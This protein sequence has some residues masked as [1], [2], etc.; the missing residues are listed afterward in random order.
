MSSLHN[1]LT[2]DV[3]VRDPKG[4]IV[5]QQKKQ[6]GKSLLLAWHRV[7]H[8]V[9]GGINPNNITDTGGASRGL[10]GGPG[11]GHEQ[12]AFNVAAAAA[13]ATNGI[14][15]GRGNTAVSL[16]DNALGTP[17]A[18][19][20]GANQLNYAI[21]VVTHTEGVASD[22]IHVQRTAT[23]NSAAPITVKEIGLIA[24]SLS[25]GW[26]FLLVRDVITDT[27]VAIGQSI[28]VTFHLHN[29]L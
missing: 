12:T 18:E 19:G 15:V 24:S 20:V 9:M 6:T 23:N 4:E 5:S 7:I 3:V 17:I 8:G 27:P 26:H 16:G 10:D 14:T 29:M 21:V 25:T 1:V 22:T 2:Y 13:T 11:A 28:T